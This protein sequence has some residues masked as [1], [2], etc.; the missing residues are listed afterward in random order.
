MRN[1]NPLAKKKFSV[2]AHNRDGRRTAD[3]M[4]THSTTLSMT[5]TLRC[6][7]TRPSQQGRVL[8]AARGSPRLRS[9]PPGLSGSAEALQVPS[10]APQTG[11]ITTLSMMLSMTEALRCVSARPVPCGTLADENP[12]FAKKK[13]PWSTIGTGTRCTARFFAS[14][15]RAARALSEYGPPRCRCFRCCARRGQESLSDI[16]ADPP[17]QRAAPHSSVRSAGC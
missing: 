14:P 11:S 6:A 13:S 1:R 9:A 7:S 16:I 17:K 3:S 12:K 15:P 5:G 10:R 4:T 8:G 2:L